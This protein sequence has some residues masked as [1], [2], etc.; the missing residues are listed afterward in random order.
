MLDVVVNHMAWKGNPNLDA[1]SQ[2]SPFDSSDYFHTPCLI[3]QVPD[4][5]ISTL[6]NCWLGD[7]VVALPDLR[8]ESPNVASMLASWIEGLVANYSVD[9]LRIDSAL[10]V[11]PQFFPNFL[12][13][14]GTFATGETMDGNA[15]ISCVYQ[16]NSI[17]SILN[18]PI[19]YPLARAFTSSQGSFSELVADIAWV[20]RSCSDPTTLAT[21]SENHDVA[22]FA[23]LT[24]DL[25]LAANILTYVVMQPGIPIVYYGAE[26]HLAGSTILS[27]NRQALWLNG[28]NTSAPLYQLLAKLNALRNHAVATSNYARSQSYVAYQDSNTIAFL[29]HAH[30]GKSTTV[31]ILTNNG[32]DAGQYTVDVSTSLTPGTNMTNILSCK[33][34][35]LSTK[36]S[37]AAEMQEGMPQVYYPSDSLDGSGLCGRSLSVKSSTS[38]SSSS[39]T[40]HQNAVSR[41]VV[42]GLAWELVLAMSIGWAVHMGVV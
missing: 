16:A 2:F 1:Y 37:L 19:Y 42:G 5:N 23:S 31:T 38:N 34:L 3:S 28:Y 12:A 32:A 30:D 8:T 39:S 17:G 35:I 41:L 36:G 27:A 29:R 22:R 18:Y 13:A 7:D 26:Q 21:F 9:G 24:G 11:E 25:A 10:N 15:S 6:E 33:S 4:A 14:A 20:N 40:G